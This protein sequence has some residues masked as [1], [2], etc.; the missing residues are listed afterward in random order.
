MLPGLIVIVHFAQ[1]DTDIRVTRDRLIKAASPIVIALCEPKIALLGLA[2]FPS[3]YTRGN[4]F[5]V[6]PETIAV[7]FL[8]HL[9]RSWLEPQPFRLVQLRDRFADILQRV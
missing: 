8:L 5:R 1:G 7:R 3:K 2:G 4:Q 9:A 6:R